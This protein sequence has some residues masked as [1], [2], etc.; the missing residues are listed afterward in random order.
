VEADSRFGTARREF[1]P[2]VHTLAL[3][4][5]LP[6]L[7]WHSRPDGHCD[8]C[9]RSWLRYT[10][11]VPDQESGSGWL[12]CFH[13]DD[14]P[15]FE[16]QLR[17]ALR[18]R[19]PFEIERRLRRHDGVY[20]WFLIAAAPVT[21]AD[22]EYTGHA[23]T[24]LDLTVHRSAA[25]GIRVRSALLAHTR[26]ALFVMGLDGAIRDAN[27]AAE[28]MYGYSHDELLASNVSD[29]RA[30]ESQVSLASDLARAAKEGLLFET[31]HWRKDGT[32]FQVE[33]NSQA[34]LVDGEPLLVSVIRD[35]SE[36]RRME[37]Q[38]RASE[39]RYRSLFENMREGVAIHDL[40]CEDG[41]VVNYRI[42]NVNPAFSRH[43]GIPF[44][45][46]AGRLATELFGTPAAP[47]LDACRRVVS[48]GLSVSFESYLA[49]INRH[50]AVS[51]FSLGGTQFATIFSDVTER[52][53]VEEQFRQSQKMEAVGRLAGGIAHDFN[54][55]L[56]IILAHADMLLEDVG[57][58]PL[59]RGIE[60]INEAGERAA[61]LTSQLLTFSRKQV[62]QPRVLDLNQVV[63]ETGDMVRRVIGEDVDLEIVPGE[64]LRLIRGDP[65]QI[66]QVILNLVVNARD[67]MPHGGRLTIETSNVA[68][69]GTPEQGA[70]PPGGYVL[71]SV[72]DTGTGMNA[73]VQSHLFE[74]FFTTK[75]TGRGTG[76]GLS[77]V[78]GIVKQCGGEVMVESEPGLG[79]RFDIYLPATAESAVPE[80]TGRAPVER[81]AE[82]ETILLVEDDRN[83]RELVSRLLSGLGYHV[84][85]AANGQEALAPLG[86]SEKKVHLLLTDVVM[87]GMSGP[88]LAAYA[89]A[90]RPGLPVLFV[91]GYPDVAISQR[92]VEVD[93]ES[94]VQ[95][96]FTADVL[97]GRIRRL[98]HPS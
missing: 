23:G 83:V 56:T 97:S 4:D 93:P 86:A 6:A 31:V 45:S 10:G 39:A 16:E 47:F 44:E 66:S 26:D 74:P 42:V 50:L 73:E 67:A 19:L 81:G 69:Q 34:A 71:L 54:N 52:K 49:T 87:P 57:E 95:K 20:R 46:A 48:S 18:N 40:I 8:Y 92:G 41:K 3:V 89:R 76:L 5:E 72:S 94:F 79:T 53:R 32:R 43:T 2:F 82:G 37:G 75:P 13:P 27:P 90:I 70:I 14:L 24:C 25:S 96:P 55:L 60:S 28:I 88:E 9:N 64:A 65:G 91:S 58:G 51:V 38:L 29:L 78:Y 17:S 15:G 33:V 7:I 22:G 61:K 30:P 68:V 21:G 35:V 77:T 59:R 85:A 36:K 63:A 84:I 62:I 11:R 12:Q 1:L 80:K 98:L